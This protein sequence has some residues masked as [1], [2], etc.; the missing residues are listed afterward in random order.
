MFNKSN[1]AKRRGSAEGTF[2]GDVGA[3]IARCVV[4]IMLVAPPTQ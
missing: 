2:G 3:G 1:D 4:L